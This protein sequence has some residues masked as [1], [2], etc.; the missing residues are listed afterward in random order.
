M[1][2][3]NIAKK[4][5]SQILIL[6]LALPLLALFAVY[7]LIFLAGQETL[8]QTTNN[9]EFVDPPM[10]V[11]DLD[12]TS[13]TGGPVDGSAYWWVW[14][15]AQ[16]CDEDCRKALLELRQLPDLLA[17]EASRVQLA[18]ALTGQ[19]DLFTDGRIGAVRLFRIGNE[20]S[21]ADGLYIVDPAGNVVLHY[22]MGSAMQ[23]LAEDLRKMLRAAVDA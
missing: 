2:D 10:M 12:L 23:A 21:L 18:L 11:R 3:Q 7:S 14:I 8:L 15:V 6:V 20:N 19:T 4:N 13:A 17:N 22:P 5:R 9:G 1:A 16:N